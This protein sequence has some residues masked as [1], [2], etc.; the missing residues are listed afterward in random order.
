MNI[1]A[2]GGRGTEG[3]GGGAPCPPLRQSNGLDNLEDG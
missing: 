1:E 3:G 2:S